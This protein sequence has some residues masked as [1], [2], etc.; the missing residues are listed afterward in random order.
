MMPLLFWP[1]ASAGL[2]DRQKALPSGQHVEDV[3][4]NELG[5]FRHHMLPSRS[6]GEEQLGR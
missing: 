3:Q 1:R 6:P 4:E 2:D 5:Y